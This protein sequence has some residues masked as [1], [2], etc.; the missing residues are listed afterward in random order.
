KSQCK[1]FNA[2]FMFKL[3]EH[4]RDDMNVEYL[5]IEI[6]HHP[7]IEHYEGIKFDNQTS[8]EYKNTFV[9]IP[10]DIPFRPKQQTPRPVIKGCQTA[11]VVGQ[12]N[13]E[14]ETDEHGRIHIQFHWDREGKFDEKSSCWIRVS[15][16]TAGASWGSIVI[17]RVGQEVIVDFLEGNP[18]QPIVI[19]CVYH[20]ENRPPYKLA[21]EKTKSTFKS[22]SYKGDGGF[23]EI[24]F[25]DL[26]DNEE[27][28]IHAEKNMLTIVENDR[29]QA[30]VEGEDQLIIEK[31]GRTIQIPKGEYL[32]EAKSIK[33]KATSGIDLMCGGGIISISQ[34]GSITIKGTTVHIN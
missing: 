21:D 33:L 22:N 13:E 32:L 16:S 27:I 18:D 5:L 4:Y 15:Q 23:N 26:K 30:I 6:K 11:I 25:E 14:I 17:P 29:K 19:G 1:A 24:R 10:S 2:G 9:C 7:F 28:F 3:Q 31:K 12:K 20:G 8:Q 34:T